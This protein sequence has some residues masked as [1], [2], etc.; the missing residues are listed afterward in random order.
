[1]ARKKKTQQPPEKMKKVVIKVLKEGQINWVHFSA[2]PEKVYKKFFKVC[3]T[4][5]SDLNRFLSKWCKQDF[6]VTLRM[7]KYDD[8]V[9]LKKAV[10]ERFQ[11]EY[12]ELYGS[13]EMPMVKGWVRMWLTQHMKEEIAAHG[14]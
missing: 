1:M 2:V 5:P 11:S 6:D 9:H 12:P 3:E 14:K 13:R 10:V 8:I 4:E 7:Y